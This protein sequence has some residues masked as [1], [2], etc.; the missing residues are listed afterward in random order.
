M[1]LFKF[2]L[3]KMRES[4]NFSFSVAWTTFQVL[5]KLR[6]LVA[7]ELDSVGT[8]QFHHCRKVYETTLRKLKVLT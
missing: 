3:V 5:H 7:V 8:K 4:L 1:C 6:Q 2:K